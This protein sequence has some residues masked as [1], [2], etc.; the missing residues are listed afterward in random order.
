MLFSRT[1]TLGSLEAAGELVL[2]FAETCVLHLLSFS[3]LATEI[4]QL[5]SLRGWNSAPAFH[6]LPC[7]DMLNMVLHTSVVRLG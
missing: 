4:S 1:G 5:E 7:S 3:S 2:H 6:Q